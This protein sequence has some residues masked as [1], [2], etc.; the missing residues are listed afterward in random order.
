L[1]WVPNI[2]HDDRNRLR[3]VLS[4]PHAFRPLGDEDIHME[5]DQFGS[6]RGEALESPL[7]KAVLDGEIVPLRPAAPAQRVAEGL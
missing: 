4:S 7:G 2:P 1:D 5:T 3:G 6:E